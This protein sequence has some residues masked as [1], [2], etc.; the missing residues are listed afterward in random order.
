MQRCAA[1]KGDHRKAFDVTPVFHRVHAGGIGHVL[2]DHLGHGKGGVLWLQPGPGQPPVQRMP[3]GRLVQRQPSPGKALRIQPPQHKIGIRHR[4][5]AAATPI[6]GR[7]RLRSRRARPDPHLSHGIHRGNRSATGADL[8]H[9]DHRSRDDHPR[10]LLEP[11]GP[12]D[13]ELAGGLGAPLLDKADLGRRAAHV[14]TQR[15]IEPMRAG[16]A[17]GIDRASRRAGFQQPHRLLGRRFDADQPAAGMHQEHRCANARRLQPVTQ[18]RQIGRHHG[19]HIGIGHRGVDPWQFAHLRRHHRRQRHR[20]AGQGFG[21]GIAHATLMLGIGIGMQETHRHRAIS[22]GP[23]RLDQPRDL[24]LV[25]P[26][27]HLAPRR[28]PLARAEPVLARHQRHRQHEVQVVL[29]EPVFA[30]HLDDI[31]KALGG[32]QGGMRAA[33]LDQCIGHKGR[34]VDH[35]SDLVRGHPGPRAGLQRGA[36]DR[37]LGH[38]VVGQYLGRGQ[39][40]G[41]LQRDIG[42]GAADIDPDPRSHITARSA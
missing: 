20:N 5:I 25:Q 12:G 32:D 31:P 11:V 35:L 1:A 36:Q 26:Q 42:E 17:R 23:H 27:Q 16:K 41:V 19:A 15:R 40:A 10:P 22:A 8:D 4:W 7:S 14:K 38:G 18:P 28:H 37:G 3:R 2:V 13:L 6:A 34:A 39:P 21:Q 29:L 24:G 9:L 33:P 30:A